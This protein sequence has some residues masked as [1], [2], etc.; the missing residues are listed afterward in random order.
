MASRTFLGDADLAAARLQLSSKPQS[1]HLRP[2]SVRKN[3]L[4]TTPF[5][6]SEWLGTRLLARLSQHPNWSRSRPVA[7][8]SWARGELC[9]KSDIDL[10]FLGDE[11]I[12][13]PLVD[14]FSAEG[15]KLRY[16]VPFDQSDWTV[17]VE[18]FDIL[19]LYSARA[20][21]SADGPA[22]AQQID[23]INGRGVRYIRSLCAAMFAEREAREKR[24]D[25]IANYLEPNLKHGSGG[26]RD[27][28]QGLLLQKLFRL[29]DKEAERLKSFKSFFL[30]IRHYLHLHDA[31]DILVGPSQKDLA[32]FLN[33]PSVQKFMSELEYSLHEV[34]FFADW[35]AELVRKPKK[36]RDIQKKNVKSTD[37]AF[38][39]IASDASLSAQKK[40]RDAD[41]APLLRTAERDKSLAATLKKHFNPQMGL[42]TLEGLF[43]SQLM[44]RV[45]PELERVTGLVQHDQ[46]HRYSVDAHTLQATR[47]VLRVRATPKILG[48]LAPIASA[49]NSQGW[50]VLLWSALYHDLGK[51]SDGDHS[52]VGARI[53]KRDF[54]KFGLPLKLTT[55]VAWLVQNH[56]ILSQ[57]AFRRNIQDPATWADLFKRG[58]RD[59]RISLLT[60]FTAIDIRATN[61]DAWNEWKQ[62]LLFQLARTLESPSA[63][64]LNQFLVYAEKKRVAVAREFIDHL[65]P[66][67]VESL[68]PSVLLADYKKLLK[69][70]NDLPPLVVSA[71]KKSTEVWVRLHSRVDRPG[72]FVDFAT[73]LHG[74][75]L[76]VQEAFVQ[77]YGQYGAYDWFKVKS[78]RRVSSLKNIL[79]QA[80]R[81]RAQISSEAIKFQ[82]I[83]LVSENENTVTISFRGRDQRGAMLAAAQAIY[84]AGFEI[85]SA[86]VH[87]W[88]RQID[89]VFTLKKPTDGPNGSLKAHDLERV[90]RQMFSV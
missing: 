17:N 6:F 27:L 65:E 57:A 58:V 71:R 88:G 68:S 24:Y 86:K 62:K 14:D 21:S 1:G 10:L 33:Y 85:V 20:F 81:Q 16:R 47:E 26:L 3:F 52:T 60:L 36:E 41:L 63:D 84:R 73:Q 80:S 37:G 12:V 61:P 8:G 69:A 74:A 89:D 29:P 15:L 49:L 78:D 45:I 53:V 4:L 59:Q 66:Q 50:E 82:T 28:E 30:M 43:R 19:A 22:I 51:G 2:E 83:E 25:S 76:N 9:A 48:V 70:K 39:L 44:A 32:E 77:T 40:V 55:Q 5:E 75:G 34:S 90:L 11:A 67:V 79:A 64:H 38:A 87:T 42:K 56:L 31:A 54:I 7:L 35:Y 18:P 13:K 72:L 46:Y 23:K